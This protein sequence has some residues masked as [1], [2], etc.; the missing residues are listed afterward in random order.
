MYPSNNNINIKNDVSIGNL[1]HTHGQSCNNIIDSHISSSNSSPT[2]VHNDQPIASFVDHQAIY[3]NH[4]GTNNNNQ[5][6]SHSDNT[7][8]NN[9]HHFLSNNL[10]LNCSGMTSITS[11]GNMG[12]VNGDAVINMN[13]ANSNLTPNGVSRNEMNAAESQTNNPL[14]QIMN[15]N[16]TSSNNQTQAIWNPTQATVNT[17]NDG[18]NSNGI[19]SNNNGSYSA[20]NNNNSSN[21]IVSNQNSFNQSSR[22]S[23]N[24]NPYQQQHQSS[25]LPNPTDGD[26]GNVPHN[27]NINDCTNTNN[28]FM[29]SFPSMMK[30]FPFNMDIR[31]GNNLN[32]IN[33]QNTVPQYVNLVPIGNNKNTH[34]NNTNNEQSNQNWSQYTNNNNKDSN[35]KNGNMVTNPDHKYGLDQSST[36][37]INNNISSR[38]A[39]PTTSNI[40]STQHKPLIGI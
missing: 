32:N 22:Y 7:T 20:C 36:G 3:G 19:Q 6:H 15:N 26:I 33:S 31:G 16:N 9:N 18:S 30:P 28:A 27:T 25:V 37:N 5:Y 40:V 34:S 38:S 11:T 8:N 24:T 21:N 4:T 2:T 14:F 12:N 10:G 35:L 39:N 29:S 23:H 1:Q 13:N 17:S